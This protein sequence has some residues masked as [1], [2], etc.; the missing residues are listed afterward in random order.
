[1]LVHNLRGT[2]ANMRSQF[3]VA[4]GL[5][6]KGLDAARELGAPS[7]I[8]GMLCS[9]GVPLYYRGQFAESAA[10]NAEAA[11][12][13][14]LLGKTSHGDPGSQQSRRASGSRKAS[15]RKLA[16]TPRSRSGSRANP[17]RMIFR[18]RSPTWAKCCFASNDV[19]L[20]RTVLNECVQLSEAI[21]KPL[22]LTEALYL[23]AS[24]ELHE[25]DRAAALAH[26]LRLRDVLAARRLDVRVPML[27][28][29]TA[30]FVL[31]SD[32][33]H[34]SHAKRWLEAVERQDDADATLR[35]KARRLLEREFGA[36]GRDPDRASQ[37]MPE[38]EREVVDFLAGVEQRAKSN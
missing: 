17:A 1:M 26:I 23:L 28:L 33:G 6:R 38:L 14:E 37:S 8:G 7:A 5:L 22:T 18:M 27:V 25:G 30:D 29:A 19:D 10:L 34:R 35:D 31:S 11:R 9:L 20:A 13:Y 2:L 3:D 16:S 15:S 32:S 24:L 4:E 21:E 36:A 12:L